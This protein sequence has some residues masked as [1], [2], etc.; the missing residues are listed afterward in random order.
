MLPRPVSR[1]FVFMYFLPPHWAQGK[2]YGR[3][4]YEHKKRQR[5]NR[6]AV[7]IGSFSFIAT[8]AGGSLMGAARSGV[9]FCAGRAAKKGKPGPFSPQNSAP[10]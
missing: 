3:N 1:R 10:N 2:K 4:E 8:A 7:L 9:H 5:S 6:R